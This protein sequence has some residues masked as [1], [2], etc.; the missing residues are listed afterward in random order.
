[1]RRVGSFDGMAATSSHP[2]RSFIIMMTMVSTKGF[3]QGASAQLF[4]RARQIMQAQAVE[5]S[6]RQEK[7]HQNDG[8]K[9]QES[10]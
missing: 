8:A 7:K 1:M 5:L 2:G 10:H 9:I 6:S 3:A 4:E